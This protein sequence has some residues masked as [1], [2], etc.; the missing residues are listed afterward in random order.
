MNAQ[1]QTWFFVFIEAC[2]IS[3]DIFFFVE[4]FLL[5]YSVLRD[6]PKT[7]AFYPYAILHRVVRFWPCYI[8][9]MLIYYRIFPHVGESAIW[10]MNRPS[11]EMCSGMWKEILFVSNLV[12][13]GRMCLDWGLAYSK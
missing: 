4:R 5:T 12:D 1:I 13:T 6:K 2:L 10:S 11:V 8:L 3:V 7:I 9:T